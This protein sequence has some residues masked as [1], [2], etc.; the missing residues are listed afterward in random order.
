MSE[1]NSQMSDD[2][3][4][5]QVTEVQ[6][7]TELPPLRVLD[8]CTGTADLAYQRA[9]NLEAAAMATYRAEQAAEY[10]HKLTGRVV[11]IV[12]YYRTPTLGHAWWCIDVSS[13]GA[14][15]E[16]TDANVQDE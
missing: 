4:Q 8:L 3:R 11:D 7:T 12:Y 15:D 2:I 6:R 10:Y 9:M 16:R 5:L 14:V 13:R 1:L